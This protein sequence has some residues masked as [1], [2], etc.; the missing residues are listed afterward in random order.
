M[1]EDLLYHLFVLNK[2]DDLHPPLTLLAGQ[3]FHFSGLQVDYR[4]YNP[5]IGILTTAPNAV[6]HLTLYWSVLAPMEV[7]YTAFSHLLDANGQFWEQ[8]DNPPVRGSYSITAWMVGE[9]IVDEY[10][11]VIPIKR[12]RASVYPRW[13]RQ[14]KG[15]MGRLYYPAEYW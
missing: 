6:L 8:K 2:T 3:G 4:C 1:L 15:K 5:Q 11:I 10:D 7:S 12:R 13:T 14:G 9:T